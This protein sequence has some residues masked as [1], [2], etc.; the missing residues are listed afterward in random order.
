MTREQI[1]EP[2]VRAWRASG[3]SVTEF[4]R[5]KEFTA[6]AMRYWI[7]RFGS[8]EAKSEPPVRLARVV[9]ASPAERPVDVA[10]KA[11]RQVGTGLFVIE[12]GGLRVHVPSDIEVSRLE[13]VLVAIGRAGRGGAV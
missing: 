2:R 4:C 13:G 1:W 11:E 9:R 10:V 5:G 12:L 8:Q 7:S 3:E 6:S